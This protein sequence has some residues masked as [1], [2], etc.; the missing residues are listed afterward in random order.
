MHMAK[1]SQMKLGASPLNPVI[2]YM[3]D[4]NAILSKPIK[5]MTAQEFLW[6]YH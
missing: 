5:N 4:C 2:C 1:Y 3:A 6:A